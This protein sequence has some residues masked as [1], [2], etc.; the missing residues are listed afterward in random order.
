MKDHLNEAR[1]CLAI[2]FGLSSLPNRSPQK[3]T[4]CCVVGFPKKSKAIKVEN[5]TAREPADAVAIKKIIEDSIGYE[6]PSSSVA[7]FRSLV[8]LRFLLQSS[9]MAVQ[10]LDG[11]PRWSIPP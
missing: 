4:C 3:T 1:Q 10:L 11:A 2:I 8:F 6:D 5:A 7:V 9:A